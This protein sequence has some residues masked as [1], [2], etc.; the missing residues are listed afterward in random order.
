MTSS[1]WCRDLAPS[2]PSF[3]PENWCHNNIQPM[4]YFG[5]YHWRSS[6]SRNVRKQLLA[7]K[8]SIRVT[9]STNSDGPKAHFSCLTC[10]FVGLLGSDW[11]TTLWLRFESWRSPL[12]KSKPVWSGLALPGSLVLWKLTWVPEPRLSSLCMCVYSWENICLYLHNKKCSILSSI[13]SHTSLSMVNS[14]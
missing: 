1:L 14:R 8:W 12:P 2:T 5:R 9:N 7:R 10:S 13:A 11:W 3:G 6:L 4:L